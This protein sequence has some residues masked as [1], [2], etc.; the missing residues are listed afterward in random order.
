[1]SG[2]IGILGL[3][4]LGL[5]LAK[6]LYEKGYEIKGSTTSSEKL[7]LLLQSRFSVR[8]IKVGDKHIEGNWKAFIQ[9]R[10]VL[11]INIPPKRTR[12]ILEEYPNQIRQ[13]VDQCPKDKKIVFVSSTSVYQNNNAEV[14]ESTVPQPNKSSGKALVEAEKIITDHFK[15]NATILR[16]A[17]L[18]GPD[19]HPG[20]FLSP[21][22]TIANPEGR[23]NLIHQED[24]IELITRIIEQ[25]SFGKV[26]NGCACEHPIRQEFYTRAA[27]ELGVQAPS[28]EE[29]GNN[30]FK[31]VKNERSKNE[32]GMVYK[33][34]NPELIF[35]ETN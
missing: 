35:S 21:D 4:W 3:G 1:M 15:E 16:F 20:R 8:I 6:S 29:N 5:P 2:K 28:F 7:M 33:Y 23:I 27:F 30:E 11:I 34:A 10:D 31:I 25:D 26:Y 9:D 18:I 32:L 17:G 13:I 14:D 24:C 12:Y 22:K 19:R